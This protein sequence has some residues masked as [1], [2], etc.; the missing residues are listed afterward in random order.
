MADA[1]DRGSVGAL[2]P[3]PKRPGGGGRDLE[4]ARA[5]GPTEAEI[6]WAYDRAEDIDE[7]RLARRIL[8][9]LQGNMKM[10]TAAPLAR[11]LAAHGKSERESFADYIRAARKYYCS[12]LTDAEVENF[13]R[14]ARRER[15]ASR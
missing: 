15:T 1:E 9:V 14:S 6:A 2:Q 13:A 3:H 5:R 11:F 4:L 12:A 10:E 8:G 7:R